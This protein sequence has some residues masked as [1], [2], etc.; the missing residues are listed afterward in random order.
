[1]KNLFFYASLF[2]SIFISGLCAEVQA[3]NL[4]IKAMIAAPDNDFIKRDLLTVPQ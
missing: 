1:M 4:A 2:M 3:T